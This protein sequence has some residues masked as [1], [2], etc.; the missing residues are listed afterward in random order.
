[1]ESLQTVVLDTNVIIKEIQEGRILKPIAKRMKKYKSKLVM[2]EII[3]GEVGKVTG[4]DPIT[5]MERV[6]QYCKHPIMMDKTNEILS[7]SQRITEKYYECHRSDSLILATAKVTGSTLVSF[8][9]D[10]LQTA[11]M[12]GVQA[13]LP[14]NYIRWG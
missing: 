8:D 7:E 14:R 10:L 6:Y 12:E 9:R 11:K 2:P 13:F 1:M 5:T 3:L 4:S